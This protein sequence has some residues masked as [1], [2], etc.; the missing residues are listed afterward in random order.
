MTAP[1]HLRMLVVGLAATVA[2]L[3]GCG[4][5]LVPHQ[6]P[7]SG[8]GC[9]SMQVK[10]SNVTLPV[11]VTP[12]PGFS[13]PSG[14]QPVGLIVDR[15]GTSAWLLATGTNEVIHVQPNGGAISYQLPFSGL[16]LQLS[17]AADGTLWVPEQYRGAVV[18]IAPDG[19][20][21]ECKLP[22]SGHE[23]MAT[24]VASDGAVWISEAASSGIVRFDKG[25]F[26]EFSIP[27]AN[28]AEVLA[29][30]DGGAWFTVD[31][32]PFLGRVTAAGEV[33]TIPVGG[34]GTCL[35]MLEM[36]DGS[37]WVA[38]FGGDRVVRVGTD[39]TLS[40]VTARAGAK[41]QS[42]A[43]G[44]DGSVWVTESGID[45]LGRVRGAKLDEVVATGAWPDHMAT[46]SSGWAWFT[47]YNQDRLGH[48]LL[49]AS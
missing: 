41:P 32:A 3:A 11:S 46:T 45:R 27:N 23:V 25:G 38:D 17:Q 10:R 8:S 9:S 19:S 14:S 36:A 40:V 24:S 44:P 2:L 47:E 6:Q 13:L 42:F 15:D 7:A 33:Q 20:V 22:G 18:A 26:K 5:G 35:G 28:G 48:M 29:A 16:G 30:S 21:R 4:Q 39:R 1:F 34:S 49:T 37:V 31:G 12:T 43:L